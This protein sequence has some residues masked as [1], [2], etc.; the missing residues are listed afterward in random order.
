MAQPTSSRP[1]GFVWIDVPVETERE[2][3]E[4]RITLRKGVK[5]EARLIGPDD[6][7]V[8]MAFGWC[9]EMAAIQ[10][11]N[12]VSPSLIP[13]GR[14][15]LEGVDPERAIRTFFIHPKPPTGGGG[16]AEV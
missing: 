15:E 6:S 8:D 4:T 14:F 5:L 12:S 9:T 11:E 10:L 16:R 7:P 2:A 3:A 13:G 1:H